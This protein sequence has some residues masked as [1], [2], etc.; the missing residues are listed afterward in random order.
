MLFQLKTGNVH[1]HE[2]DALMGLLVQ[3]IENETESLMKNNV[4]LRA[5][6]DLNKLPAKGAG[7]VK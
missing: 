6:G 7:K 5:I 2:V 4:R 1:K 3:A